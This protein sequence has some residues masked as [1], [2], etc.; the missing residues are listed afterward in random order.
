LTLTS[1]RTRISFN[2]ECDVA[3]KTSNVSVY[4]QSNFNRI[5]NAQFI[6]LITEKNEFSLRGSGWSL[7]SIDGIQLRTNKVNILKES[8]FIELPPFLRDKKALINVKNTDDKCF[9]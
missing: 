6:K 3:F 8:S 1:I 9:K 4:A 5:L 2:E 7:K